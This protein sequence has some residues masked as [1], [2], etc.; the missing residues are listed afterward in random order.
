VAEIV[1]HLVLADGEWIVY[2]RIQVPLVAF[3]VQA[4]HTLRGVSGAI[5]LMEVMSNL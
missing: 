4:V 2:E 5:W 3:I 1:G